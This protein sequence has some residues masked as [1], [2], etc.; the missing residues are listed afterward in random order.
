[1]GSKMVYTFSER[2]LRKL[3]GYFARMRKADEP[4]YDFDTLNQISDTRRFAEY[5]WAV[6][7]GSI[8]DSDFFGEF[9]PTKLPWFQDKLALYGPHGISDTLVVGYIHAIQKGDTGSSN[10]DSASAPTR[11]LPDSRVDNSNPANPAN[12][13]VANTKFRNAKAGKKKL[14][15]LKIDPELYERAKL[16][17]QSEE[18][19]FAAMVRH[20]LFQHLENNSR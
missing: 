19:T 7:T 6:S 1:M 18:R 8:K 4:G 2:Q 12:S 10:Q 5:W 17:A 15:S 13:A 16:Q 20:L 3:K 9:H 14:V 11:S